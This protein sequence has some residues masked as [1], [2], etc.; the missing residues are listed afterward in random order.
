VLERDLAQELVLEAGGLALARG[1]VIG[2]CAGRTPSLGVQSL[3]AECR[4]DLLVDR[5]Q[6]GQEHPRIFAETAAQFDER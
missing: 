4:D 1:R 2:A 6:L 3:L 5:R